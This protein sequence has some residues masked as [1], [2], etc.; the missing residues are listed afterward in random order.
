MYHAHASCFFGYT[1]WLSC[2]QQRLLQHLAKSCPAQVFQQQTVLEANMCSV[3]ELSLFPSC[4]KT[5]RPGESKEKLSFHVISV[6]RVTLL[7]LRARLEMDVALI[8]YGLSL[9]LT[10]FYPNPCLSLPNHL[11]LSAYFHLPAYCYSLL[12]ATHFLVHNIIFM[13]C[14]F[15]F[16]ISVIHY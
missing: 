14:A 4:M 13:R 5:E 11:S 6:S 1:E 2:S 3:T 16:F 15:Y 8:L 9:P 12:L 10:H 7:G